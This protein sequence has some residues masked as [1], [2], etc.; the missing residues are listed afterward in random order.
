MS[1]AWQPRDT[2]TSMQ[3]ILTKDLS[4]ALHASETLGLEVIDP[5]SQR[6]YLIVDTEV[7]P[8]SD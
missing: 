4:D 1:A 7:T 8:A 5:V 3:R 6:V 2:P